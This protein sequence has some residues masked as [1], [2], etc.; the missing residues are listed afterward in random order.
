MCIVLSF[1][2]CADMLCSTRAFQLTQQGGIVLIPRSGNFPGVGN[3]KPLQY[4]CLETS[5]DREACWAAVLV[6]MKSHTWLSMHAH[7]H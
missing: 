5:T 7:M 4:S 3:G 6:V 1:Q 2:I